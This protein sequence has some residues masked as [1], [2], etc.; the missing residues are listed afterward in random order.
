MEV[1]ETHFEGVQKSS[2]IIIKKNM[3]FAVY[4]KTHIQL[5][6]HSTISLE[7]WFS[8]LFLY[9]IEKQVYAFK[10]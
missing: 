7:Q 3:L 10:K 4:S 8:K 5:L 1:T 2:N 9:N 6:N